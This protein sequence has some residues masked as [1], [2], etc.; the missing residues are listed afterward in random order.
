MNTNQSPAPVPHPSTP[1]PEDL[2]ALRLAE[3]A[4]GE[5]SAALHDI[6]MFALDLTLTALT[7]DGI[8]A[9]LKARAYA[10]HRRI[11]QYRRQYDLRSLAEVQRAERDP[12]IDAPN[13]RAFPTAE[14]MKASA[15][16]LVDY[17]KNDPDVKA[18]QG[19]LE[20]APTSQ[21]VA[22]AGETDWAERERI[23][24]ELM[25]W[26]VLPLGAGANQYEFHKLAREAAALLRHLPVSP[27]RESRFSCFKCDDG[28]TP[29]YC[30]N[31][32]REGY[33]R[34]APHPIGNEGQTKVKGR[35]LPEDVRGFIEDITLWLQKPDDRL[36]ESR[37]KWA[38]RLY[39]KYDVE[40]WHAKQSVQPPPPPT[41]QPP[42]KEEKP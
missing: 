29:L 5:V 14:Q 27:A 8:P 2:E 3:K 11:L 19:D 25:V 20:S 40:G 13:H 22:P 24:R 38:Y 42:A 23:A 4:R 39:D 10:T 30:L 7:T 28:H 15:E 16:S 26:S 1:T 12:A 31:C 17:Y 35:G 34:S 6:A 33:E 21:P 41:T 37:F 32:A 36:R 18:W 9:E